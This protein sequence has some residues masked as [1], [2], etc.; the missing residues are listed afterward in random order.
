MTLEEMGEIKLSIDDSVT[1]FESFSSL[2]FYPN[3]CNN[4]LLSCIQ[5]ARCYLLKRS[6]LSWI[7]PHEMH[8]A[9]HPVLLQFFCVFIFLVEVPGL[10]FQ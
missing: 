6:N 2:K 3:T 4:F 8:V 10:L 7:S 5:N 1:Y 9:P